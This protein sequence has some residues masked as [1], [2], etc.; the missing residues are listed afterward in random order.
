MRKLLKKL[1]APIVR[2]LMQEELKISREELVIE[3]FR[4]VFRDSLIHTVPQT[5]ETTS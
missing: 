3:A 4:K 2:E 5:E 1:L